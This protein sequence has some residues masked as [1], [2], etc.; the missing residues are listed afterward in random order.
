M[1]ESLI[2]VYYHLVHGAQAGN[3][4]D[5]WQECGVPRHPAS[6][7]GRGFECKGPIQAPQRSQ[8]GTEAI[9]SDPIA[10]PGEKGSPAKGRDHRYGTPVLAGG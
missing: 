6:Q 2:Y 10:N 3:I 4:A 8:R 7:Q 9:L 1:N 5:I